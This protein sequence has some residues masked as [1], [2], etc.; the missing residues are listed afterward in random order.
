M[1]SS[2][3][4]TYGSRRFKGLIPVPHPEGIGDGVGQAWKR[5][6]RTGLG[7]GA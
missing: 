4:I 7:E 3:V 1:S 6:L 5:V 2:S